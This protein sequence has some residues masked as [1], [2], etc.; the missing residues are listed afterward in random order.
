[1]PALLAAGALNEILGG[2]QQIRRGTLKCDGK[3][4]NILEAEI[5]FASLD[6]ANICTV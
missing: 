5:S 4:E 2:A 3:S 6:T 1:V